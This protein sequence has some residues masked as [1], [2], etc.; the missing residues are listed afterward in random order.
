[1]AT[2]KPRP[3]RPYLSLQEA[4]AWYEIGYSTLRKLVADGKLHGRKR[5]GDKRLY[6]EVEELE[7]VL[8]PR[9]AEETGDA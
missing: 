9:S 7:R 4:A 5:P 3:T 6:L 8:T 2:V 1:M